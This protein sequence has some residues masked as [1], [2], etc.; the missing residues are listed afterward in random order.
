VYSFPQTVLAALLAMKNT[1]PERLS[2]SEMSI[3]SRICHC[4]ECDYFWVRNVRKFPDRCPH[5]HKRDWDRPI[6]RAMLGQQPLTTTP[7]H[8]S[9]PPPQEKGSL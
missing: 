3:A 2:N 7:P 6:L 1:S 8:P 9:S 4:T 5:C